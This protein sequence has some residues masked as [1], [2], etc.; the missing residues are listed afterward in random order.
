MSPFGSAGWG[1]LNL[2]ER[3]GSSRAAVA[4][5]QQIVYTYYLHLMPSAEIAARLGTSERTI[6]RDIR[7]IETDL[8]QPIANENL[9]PLK[10]AYAELEETKRQC[11]IIFDRTYR[12]Y[13]RTRI[14]TGRRA[15]SGLGSCF[16]P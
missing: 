9:R 16:H 8:K 5:R 3:P 12:R 11:W 4:K 13:R 6:Q 1:R 14:G 7:D 15:G 10:R 2:Q